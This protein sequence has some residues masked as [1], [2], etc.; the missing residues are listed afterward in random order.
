MA[1]CMEPRDHE[2]ELTPKDLWRHSAVLLSGQRMIT[3]HVAPTY[4]SDEQADGIDR[5]L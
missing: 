5:N 1:A 4:G 2:T 3:E